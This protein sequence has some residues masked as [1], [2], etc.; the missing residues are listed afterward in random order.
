MITSFIRVRGIRCTN[1][2]VC[3]S[4]GTIPT[5]EGGGAS[6]GTTPGVMGSG[7]G[8]GCSASGN[9]RTPGAAREGSGVEGAGFASL[10]SALFTVSRLC[11]W[12]VD[13]AC[14]LRL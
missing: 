1:G 10:K 3:C 4:G 9:C 7:G 2:C 11:S 6:P 12:R 13:V 8:R 5:E 14:T